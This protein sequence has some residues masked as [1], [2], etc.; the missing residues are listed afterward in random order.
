MK[1]MIEISTSSLRS[2]FQLYGQFLFSSTNY[3]Y[4]KG[5]KKFFQFLLLALGSKQMLS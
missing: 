3:S 1:T 2:D 5:E 4:V